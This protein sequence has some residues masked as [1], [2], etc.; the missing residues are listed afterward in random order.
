MYQAKDISYAFV[1]RGIEEGKPITQMKLQKLVYF[2]HG[3][4]LADTE[5]ELVKEN[6]QAWK[7]G[8]VIP[9]LY[10]VYKPYGS[11]PIDDL[12]W[13]EFTGKKPEIIQFS[14]KALEAINATWDTFKDADTIGLSNWTHKA[15]SPWSK[16]YKEGVNNIVIPNESIKNYF[17][18]FVIEEDE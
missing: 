2:A 3:L 6:F 5:K 15:D 14:P 9:E 1:R 4:H 7:F 13:L 10:D 16:V 12:F 8:P 17:K 18:Q 11:K